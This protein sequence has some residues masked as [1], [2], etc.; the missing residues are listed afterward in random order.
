MLMV[1]FLYYV[2]NEQIAISN[3]EV[4]VIFICTEVILPETL[5]ITPPSE[6]QETDGGRTG[7]TEREV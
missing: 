4:V 1:N 6:K 7:R 2:S 3:Y 5:Q